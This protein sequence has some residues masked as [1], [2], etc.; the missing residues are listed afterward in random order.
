MPQEKNAF[1][2]ELDDLGGLSNGEQ[3]CD[4]IRPPLRSTENPNVTNPSAPRTT[5]LLQSQCLHTNPGKLMEISEETCTSSGKTVN[6]KEID[7]NKRLPINSA[8]A[9][10]GRAVSKRRRLNSIQL[11]PESRQ[12]FKGLVFCE[13]RL[14]RWISVSVDSADCSYSFH[15]QQ[16]HRT[17]TP[18]ANQKG[19]GIWCLSGW[20]MASRCDPCNSG[21]RYI[22]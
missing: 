6:K 19:S 7:Q 16:W 4:D 17:S 3:D 22:L 12:I 14:S 21:Q 11:V 10:I 5:P 15:S 9:K 20:H 8:H 13:W 18:Y 1:F 2:R